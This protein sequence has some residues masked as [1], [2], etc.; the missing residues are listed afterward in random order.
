VTT[1]TVASEKSGAQSDI[2]YFSTLSSQPTKPVAVRTESINSS[3]IAVH[4]RKPFDSNGVIAY[5]HVR[6]QKMKDQH[7][8]LSVRN[9]C[10]N[11]EF[12]RR[13]IFY[14]LF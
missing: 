7:K 3:A 8:H 12:L 4:W 1:Y 6:W 9:Y 14:F 5:Y 2:I 10:N 13:I 11:R